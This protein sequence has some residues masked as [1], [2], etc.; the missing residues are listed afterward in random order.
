MLWLCISIMAVAVVF[1]AFYLVEKIKGYTPKELLLK[2]VV[3]LLFIVLAV[4]CSFVKSGHILNIFII[5]GLVFGFTGD[6]WLDLKYIY[7]KDDKIYTYAGFIVF[8]VGHIFFIT[9]M[10]LEFLNNAHFLYILIPI[11]IA[12]VLAIANQFL[13]KPLKLDFKDMKWIAFSYSIFLFSLPLC[14]ASLCIINGWQNTTLLLLFIGGVIFVL[15]DLVLSGTY[16]G[17]GHEK[18]IDFFF[19]YLFY[20]SA[21]FIIAFS[22][23]F[24]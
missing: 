2:A 7:P 11:A 19:N 22:I 10:Y 20:Y 1:T 13:A 5:I 23:F 12:V 14:A 16:F 4:Y 18:P 9:G 15:S 3:S 17:E 21:Q 6:I 24:L 8:G